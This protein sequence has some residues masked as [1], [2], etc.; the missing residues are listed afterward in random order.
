M[1]VRLESAVVSFYLHAT[2]DPNKVLDAIDKNLGIPRNL[3]SM[4][5]MLGHFGNE[6]TV[7]EALI[8]DMQVQNLFEKIV[9]SLSASD[10]YE[11][12]SSLESRIERNL[13]L[14][15]RLNKQ[16]LVLGFI[17]LGDSDPIKLKFRFAQKPPLEIGAVKAVLS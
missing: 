17:E 10:R 13:F 4:Q 9:R 7:Y 5:R 8:S 3:F 15:L 1:N 16:R 14:H 2:E 12:S 11:L 6:I